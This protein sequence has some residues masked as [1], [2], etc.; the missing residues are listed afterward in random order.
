MFR[1]VEQGRDRHVTHRGLDE[2]RASPIASWR[3]GLCFGIEDILVN[4]PP[5]NLRVAVR[6]HDFQ[7]GA[8]G[9]PDAYNNRAVA[10]LEMRWGRLVRW[11]DYEDTS[12][13]RG[14]GHG[15]GTTGRRLSRHRQAGDT[16]RSDR[17]GPGGVGH[18]SARIDRGVACR[19][20]CGPVSDGSGPR[21]CGC[22]DGRAAEGLSK[23]YGANPRAR[24][25]RPVDRTGR[26]V[27][28][29][30]AERGRQVHDDRAAPRVGSGR[31]RA[32]L[33]SSAWTSGDAPE[34]HRRLAYVPSEANLWPSLTGA[35]VLRFLASLHGSVDEAY[36]DELIAR[37]QLDPDKKVRAYSHGNRQKVLLVA[38][39]AARADLLLLDEPTAGLDPLMEQVFRDCVIEAR[40]RGQ[41]VLLSS[42]IMSE[43]EAV[44]DRVAMLR[45]GR[46][47]EIGH[48]DVL[49]GLSHAAAGAG[50]GG[51]AGARPGGPGGG[52]RRRRRRL[53]PVES[54]VTGSMQP[55]LA[56]LAAVGVEHLTTRE[57]SLEELFMSH[58]GEV[59][60]G[61]PGAA[62]WAPP[63][64]S[65]PARRPGAPVPDGSTRP[66][67]GG[68]SGRCGSGPPSTR[69]CSGPPASSAL[70]YTTTFP[71]EAARQAV[72][73][74]TS[75][76]AAWR[77]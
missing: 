33:A 70:A 7:A 20:S 72:L 51:R 43:V 30:G 8:D 56:A 38:A 46:V 58:Y 66:S 2:C 75:S 35:E 28:L 17:A 47:I 45:A 49:R 41:T 59:D 74:G 23:H 64:S 24:R 48:L 50:P 42:H 15:P 37:F 67:P 13:G 53:R 65:R 57:P 11:E 4:G 5:W 60:A 22:G 18:S 73:A 14:V 68:P 10:F 32:P 26:G 1:P 6:A 9:G 21:R 44:C 34:L 77:C 54:A 52:D 40:G 31:P 3:R 19:R 71:T 36:R 25:A 61:A 39:F 76:D 62:P 12:Q 16:R 29:P 27:R 63:A 69:W 55:L